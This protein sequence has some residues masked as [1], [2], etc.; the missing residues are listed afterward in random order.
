MIKLH[1]LKV[2][3]IHYGMLEEFVTGI[4]S[5]LKDSYI[6]IFAYD[7]EFYLYFYNQEQRDLFYHQYRGTMEALFYDTPYG[8]MEGTEY[9]L[10]GNIAPLVEKIHEYNLVFLFLLCCNRFSKY[11]GSAK[12]AANF[13]NRIETR[14]FESFLELNK[15]DYKK[16]NAEGFYDLSKMRFNSY[17]ATEGF[18]S[19]VE[20]NR[21]YRA[22]TSIN[23]K[24]ISAGEIA[25]KIMQNHMVVVGKSGFGKSS[26]LR[27]IAYEWIARNNFVFM[28]DPHSNLAK[29]F[30]SQARQGNK[31][32]AYIKPDHEGNAG[33]N[34]FSIEGKM[35]KSVLAENIAH[36]F[37]KMSHT[38]NEYFG[39]RMGRILEIMSYV[40]IENHGNL[41]MLYTMLTNREYR[42]NMLSSSLNP[43]AQD[44]LD[45]L[46]KLEKRYPDALTPALA[47]ISELLLNDYMKGFLSPSVHELSFSRAMEQCDGIVFDLDESLLGIDGASL[48]GSILIIYLFMKALSSSFVHRE[49]MLIVDEL[50]MFTTPMLS[51]ILSEG[52]KYHLHLVLSTQGLDM[53]QPEVRAS[54]KSN[55]SNMLFFNSSLGDSRYFSD[56]LIS[57]KINN[58]MI[59]QS[60]ITLEPYH[61]FAKLGNEIFSYKTEPF[62]TDLLPAESINEDIWNDVEI[63][64][65]H[66][67]V[68][69]EDGTLTELGTYRMGGYPWRGA[70]K[71]SPEHA[72]LVKRAFEYF[73]SKGIS[74]EIP[75]QGK[76]MET[77]DGEIVFIKERDLKTPGEA[78]GKLKKYENNEYWKKSKGRNIN[79]EA[80]YSGVKLERIVR[81][82]EKAMKK[83][84]Y[85][86]IVV[87]KQE[88]EKIERILSLKKLEKYRE[89]INSSMELLFL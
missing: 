1:G 15:I 77:P 76:F 85:L 26:A 25:S 67:P 2:S 45:E 47:R 52:R 46:E 4:N 13:K 56:T 22:H 9:S 80:E 74:M 40:V 60:L 84:R 42:I 5:T 23:L 14:A 50:N 68:F 8:K 79:I 86:V 30:Y 82:V 36:I 61:G 57:S 58:D 37:H 33:I 7:G 71:E 53:L 10:S 18:Y 3:S 34:P 35:N 44:L 29:S 11:I 27:E 39:F 20:Y 89:F 28:I 66:G 87:D 83:N 78:L 41:E 65:V 63:G 6:A 38:S 43:M 48:T 70:S 51:S 72:N 69:N 59:Y 12:I 54:I 75:A 16:S 32:I 62:D 19:L 21:R 55:I 81:D 88:K 64:Y 24:V 49:A 31:Q 17:L 73:H